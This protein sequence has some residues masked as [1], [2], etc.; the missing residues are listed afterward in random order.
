MKIWKISYTAASRC[1]RNSIGFV[2]E[3]ILL[4]I[5][6]HIQRCDYCNCFFQ[7]TMKDI[8]S[9]FV[10]TSFSNLDCLGDSPLRHQILGCGWSPGLQCRLRIH[11][12]LQISGQSNLKNPASCIYKRVARV[13]N[14]RSRKK[15]PVNTGSRKIQ[16]I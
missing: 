14:V 1:M 2:R 9:D 12:S 5:L 6:F 15:P 10:P 8:F 7:V 11:S 13:G 4:P 3:K 16:L